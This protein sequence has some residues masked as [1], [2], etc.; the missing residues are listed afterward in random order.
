M[1]AEGAGKAQQRSRRVLS[2]VARR[3]WNIEVR[4]L[5]RLPADGPAI[6]CPNHISFLDSAF[7]MLVAPRNISFVGKAEYMDS[8]KTK[9]LFPMMGMI[10]I[11]RSGGDKSQG[12][13]D[14]A[15]RVLDR[16][17]LFGIFPEGTR[18]RDGF[19]YKG[20]TGA[21]RLATAVGCPIFPVGIVGTDEIQPPDARAPKL[22]KSCTIT[23]GR[24]VRPERYASEGE[25]HRVWRSMIDEVMFEIREMTGQT[26]RN[27]YAGSN[28]ES[29][30]V[31]LSQVA[32]V[33]DP[34]HPLPR[35]VG[36]N[37]EGG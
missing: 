34:T 14:V 9:F 36:A 32:H 25:P 17:E 13:L 12:A 30:D 37:S 3:L 29:E 33:Q 4:G 2:P 5:D 21:A 27:V 24:A 19:L 7:L 1:K 23:I 20:R 6:L 18:S 10:P 28:S 11:D 22:F 35:M 26:Y 15:R 16:G 8:W 31:S